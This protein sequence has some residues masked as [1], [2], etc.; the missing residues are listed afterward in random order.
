MSSRYATGTVWPGVSLQ[1]CL[2]RWLRLSVDR[3]KKTVKGCAVLTS[4]KS[5]SKIVSRGDA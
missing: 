3:E 4:S 1:W 2:W 5:S